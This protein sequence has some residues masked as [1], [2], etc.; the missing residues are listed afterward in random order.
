M[1]E[2]PGQS[3]ISQPGDG[4]A[5]AG[6]R[7]RG[8]PAHAGKPGRT[9]RWG[10][11]PAWA[12]V[13]TVLV[14]ALLGAGFTVASHRDPGRALGIWV[15][16]GTVAAG[17]SVRARSAYALIPVPALAYA[18]AAAVAGLVHDRAVDITRTAL[19]VSATQWIASGFDAMTAAT[20]LAALLALARWLL[21]M[22]ATRA[23][24]R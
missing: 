12:G 7:P 16:A 15:A 4:W 17:T 23:A 20:A 9:L 10:R 8:R 1:P 19:T 13:L 18:S 5:E 14:A 22:R 21:S 24:Y 3:R 6:S 2:P 11:Y